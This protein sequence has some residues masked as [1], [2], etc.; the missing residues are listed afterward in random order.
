MFRRYLKTSSADVKELD[1]KQFFKDFCWVN[2]VIQDILEDYI[3]ELKHNTRMT[4]A[5]PH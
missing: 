4:P 5:I 2:R 1:S 3:K